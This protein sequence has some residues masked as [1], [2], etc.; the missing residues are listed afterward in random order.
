MKIIC[1]TGVPD[2]PFVDENGSCSKCKSSKGITL[3]Q[4]TLF[5][6]I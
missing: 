4:N 2:E 5:L 3:D 1:N 6:K